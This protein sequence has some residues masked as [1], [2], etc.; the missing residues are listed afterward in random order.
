MIGCRYKHKRK[1]DIY[2]V[3]EVANKHATDRVKF[4]EMVVYVDPQRRVWARQ[5]AEFLANFS[6]HE[7]KPRQPRNEKV[8]HVSV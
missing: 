3:L 7:G 4:P 6:L 8:M 1:G 2:C 5:K